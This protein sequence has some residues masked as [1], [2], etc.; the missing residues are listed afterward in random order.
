MKNHYMKEYGKRLLGNGAVTAA[1]LLK[2]K[3]PRDA[4]VESAE[5][6][7]LSA[8]KLSTSGGWTE[9]IHHGNGKKKWMRQ[10]GRKKRE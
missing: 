8:M 6:R 5:E 9:E 7:K 3:M 2:D 1:W 4:N 10:W